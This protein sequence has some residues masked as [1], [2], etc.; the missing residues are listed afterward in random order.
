M[1]QIFDNKI[2]QFLFNTFKNQ[3]NIEISINR[4]INDA[5]ILYQFLNDKFGIVDNMSDSEV[6]KVKLQLDKWKKNK[7]KISNILNNIIKQLNTIN[8]IFKVMETIIK[9]A[10]III[11]I[12]KLLPIPARF[13]TSGIIVTFSDKVQKA[14]RKIEFLATII[15]NTRILLSKVIQILTKIQSL[16]KILGQII[17]LIEAFLALRNKKFSE[18]KLLENNEIIQEIQLN[19]SIPNIGGSNVIGTYNNFIFELRQENNPSFQIGEIKR[20]YAVAIDSRGYERIKS[21]ASF[22]SDPQVLIDELRFI[23]DRDNLKA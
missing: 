14:D 1:S 4:N 23:I 18:E 16:L 6:E 22:A 5:N 7:N 8:N 3:A 13:L 2:K 17:T 19:L 9:I 21:E 11:K 15:S 20:N 12:L 10:Q